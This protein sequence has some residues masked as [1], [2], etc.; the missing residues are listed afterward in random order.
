MV[1]STSDDTVVAATAPPKDQPA[2]ANASPGGKAQIAALQQV[3][4]EA[5]EDDA[6]PI[7]AMPPGTGKTGVDP[8]ERMPRSEPAKERMAYTIQLGAFSNLEN[9]AI[10]FAFWRARNHEAY[11]AEFKDAE[12]RNWY[13]VRTGIFSQRRDASVSA[14]TLRRKES[15]SAVMVPTMVDK[16]GRP[17]AIALSDLKLPTAA[18]EPPVV[19]EPPEA[20]MAVAD[21]NV[22]A[23]LLPSE[24]V[25]DGFA[26]S[27][28]LGAFSSLENAAVSFSFWKNKGYEVFVSEI[29]DT[30][31]RTWYAVRSGAYEQRKKRFCL[32][33]VVW[34]S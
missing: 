29:K 12:G 5:V 30:E 17:S 10:S 19:P 9:A 26:Y 4:K 18:P 6:S 20:P 8:S 34:P 13:A 22:P 23:P 11:V 15:A 1:S 32:G 3:P 27:V 25:K 33:S 21:D 31:Q 14:A 2:L 24:E 7:K 16:S 28:Q